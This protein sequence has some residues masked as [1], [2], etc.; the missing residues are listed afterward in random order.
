MSL[1]MRVLYG[2]ECCGTLPVRSLPDTPEC[3]VLAF[4]R[5]EGG[6]W[7]AH[8]LWLRLSAQDGH[9]AAL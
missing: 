3:L 6:P 9:G 2:S 1:T 4:S 7:L 8:L 5:I